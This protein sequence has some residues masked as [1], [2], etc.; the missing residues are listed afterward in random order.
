M[1]SAPNG[2]DAKASKRAIRSIS[3]RRSIQARATIACRRSLVLLAG[4][5]ILE[6]ALRVLR[7]LKA[8]LAASPEVSAYALV[9]PTL[10]GSGT[11]AQ[12]RTS[13]C[14]FASM[15]FV[16]IVSVTCDEPT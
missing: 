10:A 6:R 8:G 11:A 9:A 7:R 1:T 2:R 4:E 15:F 3:L 14:C 5:A 16:V 13:T 12:C